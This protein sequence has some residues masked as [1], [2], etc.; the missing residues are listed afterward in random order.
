MPRSRKQTT[1]MVYGRVQRVPDTRL[2]KQV[3][4]WQLVGRRKRGR[5]RLQ[6][7][8][9]KSMSERNLTPEDRDDRKGWKLGVGQ[10]SRDVLDR[11]LD[12]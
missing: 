6:K 8:M 2:P 12:R 7:S 10:T 1:G 9:Q 11:L 4:Q 3:R 5:P